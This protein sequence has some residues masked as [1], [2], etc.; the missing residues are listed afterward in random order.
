MRGF[1]QTLV[2]TM[3][4][5]IRILVEGIW[6]LL[7][8]NETKTWLQWVADNWMTLVV[9]LCFCGV[10]LD[11]LVWFLRWRPYYV[12]ASS[13]RRMRRFFGGGKNRKDEQVS[14]APKRQ[15]PPPVPMQVTE[16]MPYEAGND[17]DTVWEEQNWDQPAVWE[18]QNWDQTAAWEPP[19]PAYART[20]A[21]TS[22]TIMARPRK[23]DYQEQYVRRFARPEPEQQAASVWQEDPSEEW[24][25]PQQV[26]LPEQEAAMQEESWAPEPAAQSPDEPIHPGI[27]YQ[28]LSRQYG[29]HQE[30]QS[31]GA[32]TLAEEDSAQEVQPREQE[33]AS[34]S[35][36]GLENFS[37]YRVPAPPVEREQRTERARKTRADSTP[38]SRVKSGL[39]RIAQRAGKVLTADDEESNKILDGLPPPIDKRRAFHAPVYPNRPGT[40]AKKS[41]DFRE[42]D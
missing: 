13:L 23:A 42:D 2:N 11:Y 7:F 10:V 14:R 22:D 41:P 19:E 36:T 1:T 37:P 25:E 3:F 15:Q 27:D 6:D 12:W 16:A 39:S 21:V 28:A 17:T 30:V 31:T 29:W 4:G 8:S 38:M 34:W 35:F 26:Y 20:P 5:W 32:Q 18:Q 33:E 9:F 40:D 24:T